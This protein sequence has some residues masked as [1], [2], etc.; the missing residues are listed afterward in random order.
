M[1]DHPSEG[2]ET[3][4]QLVTLK[5]GNLS[6][7]EYGLRF[8]TLATG[9]GWNELALKIVYRQ[10]LNEELLTEIACHNDQLTLDA[11]IDISIWLDIMI[12][13]HSAI[14]SALQLRKS[15]PLSP[16]NSVK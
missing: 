13:K 6:T 4:D 1:F 3:E 9:S 5:Q 2:K 7:A 14:K 8:H 16:C 10:G 15:R 12:K 11:L